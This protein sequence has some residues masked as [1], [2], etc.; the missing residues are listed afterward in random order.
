MPPMRSENGNAARPDGDAPAWT[1]LVAEDVRT[2]DPG[3]PS[4]R[5]VLV[6]GERIAW[7]G[8]AADRAPVPSGADVRR[9]DLAGAVLQPAFVDAHVHL[10][11]T[12]LALAGLDLHDCHSVDD[13]IA[14]VRAVASI[15]PGRVIMGGG[16]DELDWPDARPPT[17]EELAAAG[18]GR[19]VLLERADGHS[20]VADLRSLESAPFARSDGVER[21]AGGRPT[22]LLRREAHQLAR[23]WFLAEVP[24]VE[25]AGA[26]ERAA[27]H[28]ASLGI[29]SVHEMGGPD[30]MGVEDFDVWRTGEWP[31]EVIAYWGAMDLDFAAAR[32][33]R[34][35]GG[36]IFLDGTVGSRTA[37][38]TA[39]YADG[40][41]AGRLYESDE[42]VAAFA[43][44]AARRQLQVGF[45]AIGDAAVRQVVTALTT[46]AAGVGLGAVRRTRPRIEHCSLVPAELVGAVADLGAVASVQPGFDRMWGGPG[47]MYERRLGP[48]AGGAHPL[49]ALAD[50][51]VTLALGSDTTVTPMDPWAMVDAAVDLHQRRQALDE[52]R[53]LRAAVIGG[54]KAAR[55]QDVGLIAVGHRADLAAFEGPRGRGCCVLTMV[56]GR[57]VHAHDHTVK[58]RR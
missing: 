55:Q 45:H 43:T 42:D 19:P 50:A 44:E 12:G 27:R 9:I 2:L 29:G 4:A 37:A 10:T 51:G 23:R 14:A 7:V 34:H 6:C 33:L 57:V 25:L 54:R 22:G 53:A 52:D 3:H 16:W 17:A 56:R 21:D 49:R 15:V 24:A 40:P 35:I 36:D 28:A 11:A 41:G 30:L 1:L 38:L 46:A 5:A 39:G 13:C 31:V 8:S 32:N 20:A 26:R 58:E 47:S 48:R 18:G